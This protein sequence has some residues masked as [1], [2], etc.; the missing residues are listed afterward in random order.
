MFITAAND[1]FPDLCVWD[2]LEEEYGV[3][4]SGRRYRADFIIK[5]A[6]HVKIFI[7]IDSFR[8]HSSSEDLTRDRVRQRKWQ[9]DGW[10][11]IRFSGSEVWRD[12]DGCVQ[13]L[14]AIVIRHLIDL[15]L[16]KET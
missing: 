9:L 4:L 12:P 16:L 1:V 14:I 8:H 15:K 6:P 3:T 5:L 2:W 10:Y 7:E 13:E 11:P